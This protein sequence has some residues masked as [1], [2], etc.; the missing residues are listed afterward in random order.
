M[1]GDLA[2]QQFRV[3][4]WEAEVAAAGREQG[5]ALAAGSRIHQQMIDE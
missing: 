3:R 4:R 5:D 2:A 1:S